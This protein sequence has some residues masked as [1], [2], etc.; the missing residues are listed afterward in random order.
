MIA[1]SPKTET[2]SNPIFLAVNS[3]SRAGVV[4]AQERMFIIP[5]QPPLK[6]PGLELG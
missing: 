1:L 2:I 4:L 5:I 6:L 3:T